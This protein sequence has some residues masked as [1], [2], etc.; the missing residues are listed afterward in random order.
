M[1]IRWNELIFWFIIFEIHD[2]LRA[3]KQFGTTLKSAKQTKR[4]ICR[5][6]E[7]RVRA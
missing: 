7:A 4:E 3:Q 5:Y 2:E 6:S 1:F